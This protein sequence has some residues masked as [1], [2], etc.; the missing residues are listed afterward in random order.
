LAELLWVK[1]TLAEQTQMV[2]AEASLNR[3]MAGIFHIALTTLQTQTRPGSH[4]FP[5]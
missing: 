1:E 4:L 5:R 3:C 2:K